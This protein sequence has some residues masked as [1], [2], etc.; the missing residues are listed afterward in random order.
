MCGLL[1]AERVYWNPILNRTRLWRDHPL[2]DKLR[3]ALSEPEK[4]E[5]NQCVILHRAA[6]YEWVPQGCPRRPPPMPR[7]LTVSTQIRQGDINNH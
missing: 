5:R 3:T 2:G 4:G 7:V 6:A 1:V